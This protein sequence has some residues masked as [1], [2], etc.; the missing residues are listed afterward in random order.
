[1]KKNNTRLISISAVLLMLLTSSMNMFVQSASAQGIP[2]PDDLVMATIWGP[3]TIDPAWSYDTASATVIMQCYDTLINFKVDRTKNPIEQGLTDEFEPN[4]ATEWL[5]SQPPHPDAP[6]YTNSTYYFK[7]REGVQWHDPAYG[8][9]QPS[10]VEYSFER[11]MAFDRSG[12][13]TWMIY[14]PLLNAYAAD[15]SDPEWPQKID[16]AVESNSTHVWFNLAAPNYPPMIFMQVIAQAWAGIMPNEWAYEHGCWPGEAHPEENPYTNATMFAYYDPEVSP[17]DDWPIGSGQRIECGSGPYMLTVF[18]TVE[19]VWKVEWFENYWQGWPAPGCNGYLKTVTTYG[20]DEWGTRKTMFLA[21]DA[22]FCYVPTSHLPE[23]VTNWDESPSWAE[24]LYPD[25]IRCFPGLPTLAETNLFFNFMIETAGNVHMGDA[26]YDELHE[27]GIPS[28]FFG[29]VNVRKAF[30][31]SFDWDTYIRDVFLGEA[32]Q[33]A[34]PHVEGLAYDEYV[35]DVGDPDLNPPDTILAPPYDQPLLPNG[36][37]PLPPVPMYYFNL[38]KAEDYFKA[39]Y[40]GELWDSGFTFDILFNTG[41]EERETAALMLKESVESLNPK[42]HVNVIEVDWP[43]YLGELVGMRLTLFIIGWLADYPD[44]HNWYYPYMHSQGT[45]SYFQSYA[46]PEVDALVEAGVAETDD[47]KRIDIYWKLGNK[48]FEDAVSL[49]LVQATGRHWERTWIS[50]WYYNPIY[51]GNYY[52]HIWKEWYTPPAPPATVT[53]S[54]VLGMNLPIEA[55]FTNPLTEDPA[56]GFLVYIQKSTDKETWTNI[57]AAIT[58]DDGAIDVSV[59]P[60]LGTVYYRVYFTGYTAKNYTMLAGTTM[61]SK[62]YFE[63]LIDNN[64]LPLVLLSEV[65]AEYEVDTQSLNTILSDATAS[66]A[67]SSDVNALSSDIAAL[68]STV[69]TFQTTLYAS[70]GLAVV[71]IIIAIVAI[72]KK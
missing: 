19:H 5:L 25:G 3:A 57:G 8:T 41:N 65:G 4:L 13:P 17:L 68:Q 62:T 22:D 30:A 37:G 72:V 15:Y 11:W 38:E 59:V 18:D 71:A 40:D 20:I 16:N 35:W 36:T 67:T 26:P 10:D 33:P 24:E 43:T 45:F 50:G 56:A 2:N 54:N 69:N 1:L 51:P 9:V 58:D 12:G 60:P 46:N 39:A 7:I 27:T 29:D 23:M 63:G 31:Y 55:T 53:T 66:L 32:K 42:F 64:Q 47:N 61:L 49:P 48:Y 21:G 44:P 34:T 28:W 70:L 6:D 14:E 52:Y